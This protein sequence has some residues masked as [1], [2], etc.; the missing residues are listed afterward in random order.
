MFVRILA[1]D[2][3]GTGLHAAGGINGGGSCGVPRTLFGIDFTVWPVFNVQPFDVTTR[4]LV[5]DRHTGDTV[6]RS[7]WAI[8]NTSER[9][10][11]CA[12]A[13]HVR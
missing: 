12:G 3:R 8:A 4:K 2:L 7:H 9:S 11:A 10:P 5:D 6:T 13:R 1:F